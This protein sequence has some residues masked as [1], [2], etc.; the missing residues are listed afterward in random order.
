M[1]IFLEIIK[2]RFKSYPDL[3]CG[4]INKSN[5]GVTACFHKLF[6]LM[7]PFIPGKQFKRR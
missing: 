2:I 3:T 1:F 4:A 6:I 7:L 5:N